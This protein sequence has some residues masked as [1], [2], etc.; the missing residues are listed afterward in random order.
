MKRYI[1]F[2]FLS[3]LAHLYFFQI[4]YPI[5][6]FQNPGIRIFLESGEKQSVIP[7][8][9]K[10]PVAELVKEK[11]EA[12]SGPVE[13]TSGEIQQEPLPE[14]NQQTSDGYKK[15]EKRDESIQENS[16]SKGGEEKKSPDGNF[17]FQVGIPESASKGGIPGAG[18]NADGSS[19]GGSGGFSGSS[20]GEEKEGK[21]NVLEAYQKLV[22]KKIESHKE[23]PL[24]ARRLALEGTVEVRFILTRE[25]KV[26][27]VEIV[28]SSGFLLLDN[29]GKKAVER[30][31]PFPP[32]PDEIRESTLTFSLSFRFSLKD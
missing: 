10:A 4:I 20:G 14:E 24:Q 17:A 21:E 27:E 28:K 29:A 25:G 2:L 8:E 3:V 5:P 11:I 18:G 23:Y 22:R 26:K 16:E 19:S 13:E 9:K 7:E 15:V 12:P 32:F 6:A 31:A 30:A 1:V